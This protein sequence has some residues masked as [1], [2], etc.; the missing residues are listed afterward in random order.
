[1]QA[2]SVQLPMG[3]PRCEPEMP[4]MS[5]SMSTEE[6][7]EPACSLSCNVSS[8]GH[9]A[10]QQSIRL[11]FTALLGHLKTSK[12]QELASRNKE[13]Q[14]QTESPSTPVGKS[15]AVMVNMASLP[16]I[17]TRLVPRAARK[18]SQLL[19]VFERSILVQGVPR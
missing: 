6:A 19:T 14:P 13:S 2:S 4:R 16:R 7:D 10:K 17:A 1:M 3:F 11:L 18:M 5:T 9:D 12:T 8:T 15:S